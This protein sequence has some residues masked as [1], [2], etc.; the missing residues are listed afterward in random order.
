L[1][2]SY[3]QAVTAVARQHGFGGDLEIRHSSFPLHASYSE[4]TK[5]IVL[6]SFIHPLIYSFALA[7]EIGHQLDDERGFLAKWPST[8]LR[9][10][11]WSATILGL[12]F[13]FKIAAFAWILLKILYPAEISANWYALRHWRQYYFVVQSTTNL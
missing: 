1:N 5:T 3:I 11:R 9:I 4:R 7:H 12:S 6:G 8:Y 13:S 2:I 10:I